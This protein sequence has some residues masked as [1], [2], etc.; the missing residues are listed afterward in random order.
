MAKPTPGLRKKGNIW[1]IEKVICGQ[2]IYQSTGESELEAAERYLAQLTANIRKVQVYGERLEKTFDEAAARYVEEFDHKR[3][4]DRDLVT[5]KAV[6]PYIGQLTLAKI[7]AGSLDS[8]YLFS[9]MSTCG[10]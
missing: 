4:L 2:R 7:H 3:S 5:L 8:L 1:Q 9:V 6:M 10:F